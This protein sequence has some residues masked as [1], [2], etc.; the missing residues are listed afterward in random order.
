MLELE[1]IL[2]KPSTA[3]FGREEIRG[4]FT[5]GLLAVVT[6][7]R[8]QYLDKL[9]TISINERIVDLTS[10]FDLI[11]VLW[12]L[13]A[14]LMVLGVSDDML[15]EKEARFLRMISRYYLF[16]SYFVIGFDLIDVYYSLYPLQSMGITI[17][18][19]SVIAYWLLKRI[20]LFRKDVTDRRYSRKLLLTKTKNYL[21]SNWYGL[22]LSLFMVCFLI[23]VAGTHDEFVIPSAIIGSVFLVF[24]LF[25]RDRKNFPLKSGYETIDQIFSKFMK[26]SAFPSPVSSLE[27]V[28]K[29]VYDEIFSDR[30]ILE[31]EGKSHKIRK[32]SKLGIRFVELEGFTFIEQN[33]MKNSVWGKLAK[34]GHKILWV[35]EDGDYVAQVRDGVFHDFSKHT[36]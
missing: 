10:V 6:S 24:Y 3:Y 31:V 29:K 19:I 26:V 28:S 16:F 36:V 25:Q 35:I 5:L 20:I 17:I 15:G 34:D 12:S 22:F 30:E 7:I 8:I 23:V 13:Y 21:I 11:I 9:M 32:T 2:E 33:P 27:G 4:L 1:D 18:M 14:F